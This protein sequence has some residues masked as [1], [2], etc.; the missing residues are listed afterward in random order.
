VPP[1]GDEPRMKLF[2]SFEE[3]RLETGEKLTHGY[4]DPQ[5]NTIVATLESCAHEIGHFKDFKSGRL[6]AA[7]LKDS[8]SSRAESRIRNEIVAVLF[9]AQKIKP[10]PHL[11]R[12]EA[13]FLDWFFFAQDRKHFDIF[14]RP[15]FLSQPLKEW[16]F[17]DVQDFADWVVKEE[18]AWF[19]RLEFIFRHYLQ[20]EHI[21]LTYSSRKKRS[22]L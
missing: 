21:T 9:S 3:L 12:Y 10:G 7:S 13:D 17:S 18:H 8:P 16:K 6:R 11:L 1:I 5:T 19:E 20:S 15:E 4:F 22:S 14:A 2:R